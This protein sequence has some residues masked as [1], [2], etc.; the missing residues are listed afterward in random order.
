M[1]GFRMDVRINTDRVFGSAEVFLF[2]LV[3][4]IY[5]ATDSQ[6]G[7]DASASTR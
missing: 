6:P 2:D 7:E 5:L 1:S 4:K 3:S